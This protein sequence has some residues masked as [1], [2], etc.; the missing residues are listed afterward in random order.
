M[1]LIKIIILLLNIIS[2]YNRISINRSPRAFIWNDFSPS[3]RVFKLFKV[4]L[5]II[6]NINLV[7]EH[8][9]ILYIYVL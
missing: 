2:I 8:N 5:F 4:L 3:Y 6:V 1:Q 9:K 7:L